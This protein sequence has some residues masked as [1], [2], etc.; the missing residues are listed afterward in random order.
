MMRCVETRLNVDAA[1]IDEKF[2]A[3]AMLGT[4]HFNER[5]PDLRRLSSVSE[6]IETKHGVPAA[7]RFEHLA[8][9]MRGYLKM[10]DAFTFR[11]GELMRILT[12]CGI[13]SAAILG[14]TA[15]YYFF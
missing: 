3:C 9:Q 6:Q 15:W 8:E 5:I 13:L 11:R 4:A 14:I 7:R 2:V 1:V 12:G 10:A